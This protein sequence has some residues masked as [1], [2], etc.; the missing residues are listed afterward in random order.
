[1]VIFFFQLFTFFV[2][3]VLSTS[4]IT[5]NTIKDNLFHT[6]WSYK[7]RDR[8]V[9][10]G[11]SSG[12]LHFINIFTGEIDYS[13]DTGGDIFNSS[14]HDAYTF[15]PT[16]GN[17]F[18]AKYDPNKKSLSTNNGEIIIS[19]AQS[20]STFLVDETN[21]IVDCTKTENSFINQKSQE[22]CGIIPVNSAKVERTDNSFLLNGDNSNLPIGSTK[23]ERTDYSIILNGEHS[24]IFKYAYFDI[25]TSK[26]A[27][28]LYPQE[29]RLLTSPDGNIKLIV[30]NSIKTKQKIIG[31]PVVVFSTDGLLRFS[32]HLSDLQISSF[33]SSLPSL[34]S[35]VKTDK[36][37]QTKITS[38]SKKH[39]IA[40]TDQ[41]IFV[42][43]ERNAFSTPSPSFERNGHLP[44]KMSSSKENDK[45]IQ[46]NFIKRTDSTELKDMKFTFNAEIDL[47][48]GKTLFSTR[49]K[50]KRNENVNYF[51][52]Y[53]YN[54][55][56]NKS[57][58]A[59]PIVT[60]IAFTVAIIAIYI[61]LENEKKQRFIIYDSNCLSTETN[62]NQK[63]LKA[64][65]YDIIKKVESLASSCNKQKYFTFPLKIEEH[66]IEN[67][68]DDGYN[69]FYLVTLPSLEPFCFD[70]KF[71]AIDFLRRMLEAID[72]LHS[73]GIVHGSISEESFFM[74]PT[75]SGSAIIG[76]IEEKAHY[77][78]IKSEFEADIIALKSILKR[79]FF[80]AFL[81]CDDQIFNDFLSNNNLLNPKILLENHPIFMT[82]LQKLRIFEDAYTILSSNRSS[83]ELLKEFESGGTAIFGRTWSRG[84][85]KSLLFEASIQRRYNTSSLRDLVSLIRNKWVHRAASSSSTCSNNQRQQKVRSRKQKNSKNEDH[86]INDNCSDGRR[87]IEDVEIKAVYGNGSPE[88]YFDYFNRKFPKLFVY[89]YNFCLKQKLK[90]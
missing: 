47:N 53:N 51:T 30:N 46:Q 41:I 1:M 61:H 27:Q 67:G 90:F 26:S 73:N 82:D 50:K 42:Q 33:I 57:W 74:S 2:Q 40:Q 80:N 43:K 56:N 10:V 15:L 72:F 31:I 3:F 81:S 45:I 39:D 8:H 7:T 16:I 86:E 59:L 38:K 6:E 58:V 19:S 79:H 87:V 88:C 35:A 18:F 29:V 25:T 22:K 14:S 17:F 83:S 64:V 55:S 77:S 32:P 21:G 68:R 76:L 71:D 37:P 54:R 28:T 70:R 75:E 13:L 9:Y 4:T 12:V 23:V 60:F 36:P 24:T 62:C 5:P 85:P 34:N 84:V 49:N 52:H 69:C 44:Q 65:N 78:T 63:C 20:K 11:T 48:K 89:V 66:Q